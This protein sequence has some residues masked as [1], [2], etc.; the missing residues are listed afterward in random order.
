MHCQKIP[1]ARNLT[2]AGVV[3]LLAVVSGACSSGGAASVADTASTASTASKPSTTT[4][5]SEALGSDKQFPEGL[6]NVRYCEVLL[7]RKPADQFVA[8]VWNTMGMSDCPQGEWDSLDAKA[9]ATERG[10]VVALKNGPRYWTL[11]TIVS[12][13]RPTAPTTMFG[14]I[15][16]FRAATVDLGPSLPDQ[17]AYTSRSVN[18]ETVFRFRAGAEVYELTDPDGRQYI[19]QSYALVKDPTLT[20]DELATLGSVLHPPAGWTYRSRVLDQSLDVFSTDGVATVI[21]D[22]LQNSYQRIDR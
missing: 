5:Q 14:P 19:M 7:L 17:T 20:I 2:L 8:E 1:N 6:R 18:R 10:A 4:A 13:I 15:P 9:I 16:M 3:L 21:Q 12:D 22:E 11:D